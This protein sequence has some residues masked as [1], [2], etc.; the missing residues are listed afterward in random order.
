MRPRPPAKPVRSKVMRAPRPNASAALPIGAGNGDSR[1][2]S[3][4]T[5][6]T[7]LTAAAVITNARPR[8]DIPGSRETGRSTADIDLR[9]LPNHRRGR[10]ICWLRRESMG[11]FTA[12]ILPKVTLG[13]RRVSTVGENGANRRIDGVPQRRLTLRYCNAVAFLKQRIAYLQI[14]RR[15]PASNVERR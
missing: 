9:R 2:G 11:S 8:R 5:A 6:M 7:R 12:N 4:N 14:E 1:T 13:D 15:I 3:P 10:P